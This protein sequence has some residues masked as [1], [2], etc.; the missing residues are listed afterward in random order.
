MVTWSIFISLDEAGELHETKLLVARKFVSAG[1]NG[2]ILGHKSLKFTSVKG[3]CVG[4][5]QGL[6]EAV[7]KPCSWSCQ[8]LLPKRLA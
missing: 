7:L 4:R 6:E 3:R 8:L 1:V 2:Q 5:S